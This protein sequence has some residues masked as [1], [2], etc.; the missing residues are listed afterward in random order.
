MALDILWANMAEKSWIPP[1]CL[2]AGYIHIINGWARTYFVGSMHCLKNSDVSQKSFVGQGQ[3]M[4]SWASS[5]DS[6]IAGI[7]PRSGST[8]VCAS[9]AAVALELSGSAP[10]WWAW[11]LPLLLPAPRW[12]LGPF[13]ILQGQAVCLILQDPCFYPVRE[14]KSWR[15]GLYLFNLC[16]LC[17]PCRNLNLWVPLPQTCT[18]C[19]HSSQSTHS[20]A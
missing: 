7:V 18:L 2:S 13:L 10:L 8:V 19:L 12:M 16:Y 11:A 3:C 9:L 17:R 15:R 14:N 5:G 1:S 20:L 6:R 4:S